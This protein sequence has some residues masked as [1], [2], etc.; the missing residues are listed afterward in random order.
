MKVLSRDFTFKEKILL[1]I[2]VLILLAMAYYLFVDQPIRTSMA[3]AKAEKETLELELA[4]VNA[5]VAS[6][7]RMRNELEEIQ[8]GGTASRMPSYNNSEAELDLLNNVLMGTTR[9]TAAFSNV[10]RSGDQI[11]RNFTL[12]FSAPNYKSVEEI[13]SQLEESPYRCLLGD[14]TCSLRGG[15]ENSEVNVNATATFYETLVGGVADSGLP[16]EKEANTSGASSFDQAVIG[17]AAG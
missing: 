17:S 6:L 7:N 3:T 12:Q 14:V 8:A 15:D 16:E 5:Q 1:L 13:I 2:L 9:Y 11:R 4:T 10:T